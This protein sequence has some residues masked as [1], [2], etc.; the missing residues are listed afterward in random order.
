MEARFQPV[1]FGLKNAFVPLVA[2]TGS[3]GSA[4]NEFLVREAHRLAV[5]SSVL[6]VADGEGRNSVW[7]AR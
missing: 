4:P 6:C 5:P 2:R 7:L 3:G 1:N